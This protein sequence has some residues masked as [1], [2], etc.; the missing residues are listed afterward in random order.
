MNMR[1]DSVSA[2]LAGG[3]LEAA[4]AMLDEQHHGLDKVHSCPL[5]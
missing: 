5:S 3:S 1:P 4:R 2:V